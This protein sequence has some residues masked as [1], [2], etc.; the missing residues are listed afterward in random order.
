MKSTAR[1]FLGFAV[2]AFILALLPSAFA[3]KTCIFVNGN[4]FKNQSNIH[5]YTNDGSGTLTTVAGSP[6]PTGGI[7]VGPGN[8]TDHQW[9]A[10]G[11]IITNAAG[12][13]LWAVNGHTNSISAFAINADCSL[14]TV[15][16][17]P[18]ASGGT[19]PASISLREKH[20]GFADMLVVANKDSDPL[21]AQTSPNYVT[22]MVAANGALTKNAGSTFVRPAGSSLAQVNWRPT[23]AAQFY[24]NEFLNTTLAS[25]KVTQTG[26][27]TQISQIVPAFTVNGVLNGAAIHPTK[28]FYYAGQPDDHK[29]VITSFDSNGNLTYIKSASNTGLAVCWFTINAGATRLVSA[30]TPSHTL[31][32]YD[33][34]HPGSL[35]QLQQINTTQTGGGA[36]KPAHMV[37]DPTNQ[38]FLYVLD[39]N[40]YIHI[41]DVSPT[42]VLSE[43]RP[44]VKLPLTIV[45]SVP[46]GIAAITK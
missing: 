28:S 12:T 13:L 22:F 21:Q 2:A 26:V 6:F 20:V 5:V 33:M 15:P 44:A 23:G 34:T 9:D 11:E 10:D 46:V 42:Y 45:G 35:I 25:Y 8:S 1:C 30:E 29:V 41:D 4:E 19:Q 32:V 36:A 31:T 43:T 38:K 3:Q 39:R 16:G 17:S 40:G 24:A 14:T 37:F 27:I 7:G 18:F